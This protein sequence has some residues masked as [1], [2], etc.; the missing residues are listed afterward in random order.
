M[1]LK[2]SRGDIVGIRTPE[3]QFIPIRS[4]Y[5]ITERK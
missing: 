2:S 1:D 5:I 4:L 3:N